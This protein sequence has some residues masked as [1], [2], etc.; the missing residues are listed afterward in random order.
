M[1][2]SVDTAVLRGASV[3]VDARR[4]GR[5]LAGTGLAAL[6]VLVAALFWAGARHNSRIDRLRADGVPVTATVS[7]CRG[8]M[9][10]TGSNLAGY[11]CT[12]TFSLDG[13][14]FQA[15]LP[16]GS[17]HARGSTV[18]LISVPADPTL[19]ATPAAVRSERASGGVYVL[20]ALLLLVLVALS[21][22]AGGA[23]R[24]A[25]YSGRSRPA[26]RSAARTS[27]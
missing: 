5:M 24:S 13:R 23:V 18:R 16:D 4:V 1:E 2:A 7:Q 21:A 26:W 8:L 14:R 22:V 25:G 27:P 9:G 6:A 3:A 10:G 20:P 17:L 15:T 11:E 19:L 12:G